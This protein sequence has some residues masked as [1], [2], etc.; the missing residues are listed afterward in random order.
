[1]G[2]TFS[3]DFF[4]I[5]LVE[6]TKVFGR[7]SQSF[8]D[9]CREKPSTVSLHFQYTDIGRNVKEITKIPFYYH[10]LGRKHKS[11]WSLPSKL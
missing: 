7:F 9:Y 2:L 3:F 6:N 4:N 1:M 8:H 11:F 10:Q 5:S